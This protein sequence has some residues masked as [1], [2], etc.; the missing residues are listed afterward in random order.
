MIE[1]QHAKKQ[2]KAAA[3]ASGTKPPAKPKAK[4]PAPVTGA[5]GATQIPYSLYG[6]PESL[7]EGLTMNGKFVAQSE[8]GTIPLIITAPHDGLMKSK[9]PQRAKGTFCCDHHTLDMALVLY[10][11]IKKALGAPTVIIQLLSRKWVDCNRGAPADPMEEAF[12]HPDGEHAY[13]TWHHAISEAISTL[14]KK[15]FNPLLIDLHG[16][17]NPQM[18]GCADPAYGAPTARYLPGLKKN[19]GDPQKFLWTGP[20]AILKGMEDNGIPVAKQGCF[21]GGYTCRHYAHFIGI[22]TLQIEFDKSFRQNIQT[23]TKCGHQLSQAVLA[24]LQNYQLHA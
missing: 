9:D 5:K 24:F 2:E 18:A 4:P 1:A 20:G 15:G 8:V 12:D 17:A 19:Y 10:Q 11:E 21:S 14:K 23:A 6:L 13:N 16:S 7:W 3:A 22:N